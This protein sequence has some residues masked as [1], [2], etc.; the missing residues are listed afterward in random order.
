MKTPH[1]T[2][3]EFVE[4]ER[5]LKL[6]FSDGSH[7]E[8][9]TAFLR[10]F[11]PCAH[12]QGHSGGPPR[13]VPMRSERSDVVDDVYPVGNYAICIR[14]GDGHDTGIYAFKYLLRWD[15]PEDFDPDAIE[16]G[17]ELDADPI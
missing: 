4:A 1:P 6:D 5:L 10:G 13:W 17:T 12:C 15:V 14:W 11:C 7:R 3:I 16:A 2:A 9:P 8:L